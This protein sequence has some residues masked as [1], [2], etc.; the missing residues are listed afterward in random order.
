MEKYFL[1]ILKK[2]EIRNLNFHALRHTYATRLR[3]QKVDIKVI[4]ELLGHADWKT[5]QAIY[6]HASLDYKRNSVDELSN[7][8]SSEKFV[9]VI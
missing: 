2:L 3:E 9:K 5:T 7:L 4:S 8:W 6:I 1:S